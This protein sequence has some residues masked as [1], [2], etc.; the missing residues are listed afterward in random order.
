MKNLKALMGESYKD[1]LTLEQVESFLSGKKLVDLG[2]GQYVSVDKFNK[3]QEQLDKYKDYDTV[4]TE[5]DNLVQ[6]KTKNEYLGKVTGAK[7]DKKFAEFVLS[8]VKQDEK[9]DENLT[10]YLKDNPQFVGE[11]GTVIVNS[12]ER[13]GGGTGDKKDENQI[14]NDIFRGIKQSS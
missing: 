2:T 13:M 10:N 11:G 9:F 6:E 5:R 1:D 4:K 8:Q 12:S 3:A 7:V 14:M